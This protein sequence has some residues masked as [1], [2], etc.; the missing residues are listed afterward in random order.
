[1]TMIILKTVT[2]MDEKEFTPTGY[3]TVSNSQSVE[4][5]IADSGDAVRYR[6][7]DVLNETQCK[8]SKWQE[9]KFSKRG[10]AYFFAHSHRVYLDCV[11]NI[12]L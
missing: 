9:V 11:S 7:V 8:P 12:N 4:V 2:T 3:Y 10:R 1:M 6:D 5:Q